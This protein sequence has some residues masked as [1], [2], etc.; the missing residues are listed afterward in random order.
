VLSN[1]FTLKE[2]HGSQAF[3][4]REKEQQ[5]L[6]RFSEAK[7]NTLLYSPRR[8]GKTSLI[9]RVQATLSAGGAITAYCDLFGV[10]SIDEIAGKIARA[11]FSVT[12]KNEGIFDKA[13]RLLTSFRPVLSPSADGG[14]SLSVQPAYSTGGVEIL[15]QTLEALA[16]F[17]NSMDSLVHVV[18]DEF[19]EIV[20]VEDSLKIEASLRHHSQQTQ[21]AFVFVGSRRRILF[22][23]FNDRKRPFFQSAL[24]YELNALPREELVAFIVE[25]FKSHGKRIEHEMAAQIADLLWCHPY[26]T[27]KF[28]FFLYDLVQKRVTQK[29]LTEARQL[30]LASEKALFESTLR[31][32]TAVQIPVLTAIAKEP[33]KGL[34]AM[35][36]I[37]NHNLRSI[38]GIQLSVEL[39]SKEDLIEADPDG[40]WRVVDPLFREWLV[41][42]AI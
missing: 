21:C 40:K 12:R 7:T 11:L 10:S 17:V 26:Y 15:D 23:M 24:N 9:K 3:C 29:D 35:K 18:F 36:F 5:D 33:G 30:V 28:C 41:S 20:E 22:E 14:V 25:S 37:K 31:R 6:I 8:Y 32:L 27:Q 13:I 4:D 19:Q 16:K 42:R 39:L 1:P 2:I 38:G 34:Y